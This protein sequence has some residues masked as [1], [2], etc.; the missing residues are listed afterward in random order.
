MKNMARRNRN[1]QSPL[2]Q[3]DNLS[4]NDESVMPDRKNYLSNRTKYQIF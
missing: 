1:D 3:N 4:G 2:V